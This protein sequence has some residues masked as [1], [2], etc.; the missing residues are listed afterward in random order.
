MCSGVC[1]T[2]VASVRGGWG[3]GG[4]IESRGDETTYSARQ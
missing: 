4:G 3:A 2:G 1:G